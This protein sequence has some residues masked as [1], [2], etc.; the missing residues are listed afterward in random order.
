MNYNTDSLL[1]SDF[2]DIIFQGDPFTYHT[3]AGFQSIN[4]VYIEEFHPITWL[5]IVVDLIESYE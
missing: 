2:R 1:M 3:E 5:S 4:S